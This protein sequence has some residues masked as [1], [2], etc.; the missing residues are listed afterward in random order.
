[1]GGALWVF[2]W[3][4]REGTP[5][6]SPFV[7]SVRG[8]GGF[9]AEEIGEALGLHER[10]VRRHLAT[11]AEAGYLNTWREQ[12]GFTGIVS[13]WQA[14]IGQDVPRP[15]KVVRS[16]RDQARADKVVRSQVSDR[17]ELS[18]LGAENADRIVRSEN[19]PAPPLRVLEEL[20]LDSGSSESCSYSPPCGFNETPTAKT[21]NVVPLAALQAKR[22]AAGEQE[23][24][25]A[26][27]ERAR[28]LRHEQAILNHLQRIEAW[29]RPE[30]NRTLRETLMAVPLVHLDEVFELAWMAHRFRG[31]E[32]RNLA[33]WWAS[34]LR[35]MARECLA[36][37]AQDGTL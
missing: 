26:D 27:A 21:A 32:V 14:E 12:H 11:L 9:R 37:L 2:L 30:L 23:A 18:G 22:Q 35:R 28:R 4:W 5:G 36:S 31:G 17:T 19:P 10:T 34:T 3:L 1:M 16:E 25:A 13:L 7:R 33:G 29:E 8:G 20:S 15:D 6:E 24:A